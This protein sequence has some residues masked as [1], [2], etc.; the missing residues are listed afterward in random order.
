MVVNKKAGV[1][2]PNSSCKTL[3]LRPLFCECRV[4]WQQFSTTLAITLCTSSFMYSFPEALLNNKP[5]DQRLRNYSDKLWHLL[6]W[7][8]CPR[9]AHV[10]SLLCIAHKRHLHYRHPGVRESSSPDP[11]CTHMTHRVK[12]VRYQWR[13]FELFISNGWLL[14]PYVQ[15]VINRNETLSFS[16]S[17]PTH[18]WSTKVTGV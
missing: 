14:V 7:A 8:T 12:S 6:L 5:C 1:F 3:F 10:I 13:L 18:P 4:V 9:Y 15:L 2:L 16:M 17:S 11:S